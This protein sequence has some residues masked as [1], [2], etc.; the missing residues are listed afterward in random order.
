LTSSPDIVG[1]VI[2]TSQGKDFQHANQIVKYLNPGA[3]SLLGH[4]PEKKDSKSIIARVLQREPMLAHHTD[5]HEPLGTSG[6][7]QIIID[8][9]GRTIPPLRAAEYWIKTE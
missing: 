7:I 6:E 8:N 9:V 1:Q 4:H 5:R 3:Y 2:R